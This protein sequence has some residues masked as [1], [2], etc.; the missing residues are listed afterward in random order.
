[1][2]GWLI[3]LIKSL[4]LFFITL[5]FIKLMGKRNLSNMTVFQFINYSVIAILV[6]LLGINLISNFIFGLISLAVWI[7]A[8][9]ALDFIAMKSKQI[10]DL[11]YGKETVLI[12]DGKIMEENMGKERMTGEQL[13]KGLRSKN[14]F[15]LADVEFAIMETT[16]DVNVILKPEKK[17]ITP[18]DLGRKVA[19]QVAPQ[20][21]IIDGKALNEP[22]TNMGLNVGWLNTQLEN[23]GVSLDNVFIGQVDASGDLYVDLFDDLMNI[24]QPK[25]K[26]LMYANMEKCQADLMSFTLETE[27]PEAKKLYK[28]DSEKL[29]LLMNKLEP[30]LLR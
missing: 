19:P 3:I 4:S 15:N 7:A 10:Y 20:T 30:Y 6:A 16:G 18:K 1:M 14:V 24:P 2:A 21:I 23:I 29:K 8:P 11:L 28:Q 17:P 25:V 5:I 27:N 26:E 9:I 12:K 22:L 13:L